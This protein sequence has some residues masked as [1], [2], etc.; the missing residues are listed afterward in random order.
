MGAPAGGGGAMAGGRVCGDLGRLLG[1][2]R[3]RS[4]GGVGLLP[5][6]AARDRGCRGGGRD[7]RSLGAGGGRWGAVRR[8]RPGRRRGLRRDVGS[9]VLGAH[10]SLLSFTTV[11]D[12]PRGPGVR[13]P[14]P[15]TPGPS[16]DPSI[17]DAADMG[18]TGTG[19]A[20]AGTSSTSSTGST[21]RYDPASSFSHRASGRRKARL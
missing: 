10:R 9:L 16:P 6:A 17:K 4:A 20:P 7:V 1:L 11:P 13:G 8:L 15:R 18:H 3:A 2:R 5:G 12:R 21:H 14:T 19:S